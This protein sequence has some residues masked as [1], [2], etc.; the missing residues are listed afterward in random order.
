MK[1]LNFA[2][3]LAI[4]ILMYGCANI[5]NPGGGPKDETPPKLVK[6]NPAMNQLNFDGKKVDIFFNELISVEDPSSKVIISPPQLISPV[7]KA[8]SNKVSVMFADTMIKNTTYTID[9]T[10]AIVDYNEKNKFGDFAFSFS[11]GSQIDTF[12]ISG[13]LLDASN[14]NPVSGALIGVHK[15]LS[16]NIFK[17]KGFTRIS[18][19]N[20]EGLFSVKGLSKDTF[21]VYALGD[22]NRDYKFDQPGEP[23]AVLDGTVYPWTEPC[24]KTDTIWKDSITVD[25]IWTH[26]V[27]CY[28][29]DN[30]VLFYFYEDFGRQYLAKRERSSSEKINLVFGYKSETLP[31]L[32]LLNN[33]SKNWNLAE[34]NSTKDT[35]TYWITDTTVLKMDTLKIAIDYFKTDSTNQLAPA[36]DTLN[37]VFRR[38]IKN[39]PVNKKKK[40][41]E[42]SP[43]PVIPLEAKV[44]FEGLMN[45]YSVPNIEWETPVR[46]ITGNPWHLYINKD[47][48]WVS[49]PCKV[50]K[51]SLRLRNYILK[52]KWDFGQKYRFEIDSGMVVGIYGKVNK[53]YSSTFKIYNEEEYSRLIL[54]ISGLKEPAFVELLDKSDAVIRKEKVANGVADLKYL[55]PGTYYLRAVEDLNGNFKW[56]TG[57]FSKKIKPERV[58][59]RPT[60]VE[61]RSN[62]DHE[63]EWDV[64]S[65]PIEKQKPKELIKKAD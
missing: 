40:D 64:L 25:S 42:K 36:L 4:P 2:I 32:R 53:K 41:E 8:I 52:A 19:T 1:Q 21:R 9:F 34:V 18:K 48:S 61:L 16:D 51:D 65:Q 15:D 22:K 54:T 10:D 39:E 12:R 62:W 33:E 14:L 47:S 7:V 27:T 5:G 50:E 44:S 38:F 6:S 26:T 20:K 45:I 17:T 29:P 56:D 58:Y 31:K 23:I 59:Y 43:E 60:Q 13:V 57:N 3:I 24:L 28:K 30:L 37:L 55:K 11:T 46:E 63:E 49:I 35:L